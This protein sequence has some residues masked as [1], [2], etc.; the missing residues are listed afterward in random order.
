MSYLQEAG[1][2]KRYAKEAENLGFTLER[3]SGKHDIW[4]HE[5]GA[6]VPAPKTGSD[7]RG[8]LNFRRDLK[9]SLRNKQVELPT[10]PDKV[11]PE[12]ISPNK[13]R[14]DKVVDAVKTTRLSPAQRR[15]VNRASTS[16]TPTTFSAFMNRLKPQ[17]P[18]LQQRMS[19]GYSN[20]LKSLPLSVKAEMGNEIIK[21]MRYKPTQGHGISNIRLAD[22][23]VPEAYSKAEQ[24][25]HVKP[26]PVD[27]Q[28]ITRRVKDNNVEYSYK[29][30]LP[31]KN[32]YHNTPVIPTNIVKTKENEGIWKKEF[33]YPGIPL[34][35]LFKGGK[36]L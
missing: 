33:N 30:V 12:A 17:S 31:K 15:I 9:R 11:K 18:S 25:T 16:G 29:Q 28:T 35:H 22:E 1:D 19:Q 27:V 5:S 21:R 7:R 10:K 2:Q 8:F 36:T 24:Q 14:A 23:Y 4:K 3:S 6:Q 13:N 32:V 20:T 26:K 34:K